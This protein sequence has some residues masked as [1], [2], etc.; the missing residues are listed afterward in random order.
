MR[1]MLMA[2]VVAAAFGWP[3]TAS[4]AIPSVFGG[5]LACTAQASG[6]RFC[7]GIVPSWDG[8]PI[9]VN[10]AFPPAAGTDASWPLIGLYHGWG[11][12]K[13]PLTGN[14]SDPVQRVLA[15]GYAAFTMTDR[16]WGASCGPVNKTLA[17]CAHGYIHLMH[18]AYEVRDAQ[19]LMGRLADDGLIDPQRIGAA[20][21]SY[22]GGMAIALGALRNRVMLPDG[23]LAPW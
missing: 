9:D 16:G 2:V 17:A 3:A 6:Q 18:D 22:G 21:G 20:G 23:T 5:S 4:A 7:S 19:Y 8:T 10:V 14:G 11:G 1:R 15:R 12:T 13:L